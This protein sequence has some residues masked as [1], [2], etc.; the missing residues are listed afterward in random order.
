LARLGGH[1]LATSAQGAEQR[2]T[3]FHLIVAPRG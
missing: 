1:T 3:G 2:E